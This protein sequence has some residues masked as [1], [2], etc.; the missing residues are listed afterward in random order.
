[1]FDEMVKKKLMGLSLMKG[2]GDPESKKIFDPESKE[3]KPEEEGMFSITISVGNPGMKRKL[4]KLGK[5]IADEDPDDEEDDPLKK[6]FKGR[7]NKQY[8]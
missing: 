8:E 5:D 7:M 1:M 2:L 6:I 3:F 4:S